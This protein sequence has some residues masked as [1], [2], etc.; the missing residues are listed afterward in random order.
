MAV[1]AFSPA[2]PDNPGL[3]SSVE[4]KIHDWEKYRMR[5]QDVTLKEKNK[6]M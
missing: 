4:S 6:V 1:P 2:V 3:L 5:Q